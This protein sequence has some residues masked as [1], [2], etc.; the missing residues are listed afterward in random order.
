MKTTV[1]SLPQ[2]I[3]EFTELRNQLAITPQGGAT[4]F[5]IAL[6]IYASNEQLGHQC[7]VLSVDRKLLSEGNVYK[8]FQLSRSDISRIKSQ[9]S[10]NLKLAD[11]Y[12]A[13]GSPENNYS[14]SLPY[15]YEYSTNS[16]SGS[17]ADGYM[18]LFIKCYGADSPRPIHIKKNNRNIWKVSNWSSVIVGIKKP[19]VDD[20]L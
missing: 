17:E 14:V 6:K 2:T 8:N 5:M 4:A 10:Q 3:E 1:D 7:F 20:D 15:V 18:K 19:P 11:S 16:T 12:I 13:G 9:V